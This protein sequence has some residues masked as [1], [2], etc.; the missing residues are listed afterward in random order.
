MS[1]RLQVS[2]VAFVLLALTPMNATA[3]PAVNLTATYRC[4]QGCAPG[5]EG[6]PAFIT[7]NEW[8]MNIITE[9]GVPLRAWFDW[10]SP[11][12]RIWIEALNEGAVYSLDGL[13]IQ[14]DRG[15]VWQRDQSI[16]P[17]AMAIA[18]CARR[19]RSYDPGSQ[20]Y[21][22]RDGLRHPCP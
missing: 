18:Y 12:T 3:Q 8:N 6:R 5:F 21:L 7:Q 13:T 10:F 14:F 9:S 17:Y 2:F 16:V 15:T 4:V 11:T 1:S 19:F 20:T 22:G